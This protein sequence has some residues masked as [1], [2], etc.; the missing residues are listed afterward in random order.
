MHDLVKITNLKCPF[1]ATR[2]NVL[3]A[4]SDPYV[5]YAR[6]DAGARQIEQPQERLSGEWKMAHNRTEGLKSGS[7]QNRKSP[8]AWATS[9]LPP[10]ADIRQRAGDVG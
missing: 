5:R 1:P 8:P 4:R 2:R 7:G 9:A 6:G 10:K 3:I